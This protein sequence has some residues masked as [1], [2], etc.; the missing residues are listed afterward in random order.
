M[1]CDPAKRRHGR[2]AAWWLAAAAVVLITVVAAR[3]NAAFADFV[4]PDPQGAE[5]V[6]EVERVAAGLVYTSGQSVGQVVAMVSGAFVSAGWRSRTAPAEQRGRSGTAQLLWGGA[7]LALANLVTALLI[8]TVAGE[9]LVRSAVHHDYFD[10]ELLGD[11]GIIM[12][13]LLGFVG[14]VI[15]TLIGAFVGSRGARRRR[16]NALLVLS[17][18]VA[19]A[20]NG[21][22]NIELTLLLLT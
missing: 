10:P 14:F 12:L 15:W 8:G 21:F 2:T 17:V 1:D 16:G 7:G 5:Q 19:L 11:V 4:N 18:L 6:R 9:W 3:V 22:V 13:I 20:L